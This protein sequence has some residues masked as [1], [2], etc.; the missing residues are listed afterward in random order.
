MA[1]CVLTE[2]HFLALRGIDDLGLLTFSLSSL[3]EEVASIVAGEP[4]SAEMRNL[5]KQLCERCPY[6][7]VLFAKG[8]W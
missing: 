4:T 2:V 1:N 7:K 6:V 3:I 5:Q 8:R